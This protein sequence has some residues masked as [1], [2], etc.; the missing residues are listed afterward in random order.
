MIVARVGIHGNQ[1]NNELLKSLKHQSSKFMKKETH[2]EDGINPKKILL[3]E[4]NLS[5]SLKM[6]T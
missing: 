6:K 5:L 3:T 1:L 4:V 2:E